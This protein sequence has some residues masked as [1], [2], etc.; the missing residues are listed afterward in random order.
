MDLTDKEQAFLESTRSAAM[1]TLRPDGRPHAVRV[2]FVL[3]DGKLW[4]SGTRSRVRNAHLRRDPRCTLFVFDPAYSYLT[5]E[6]NATIIDSPE[7]P[8]MSLRLFRAMQGRPAGNLLWQGAE[9]TPEEFL[10]IMAEEQRIIYE[11]E[12]VRTYG[13]YG[14]M[15][16]R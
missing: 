11:F 14:D 4:V 5:L 6:A 1:V 13:L 10:Q 9:C 8:E 16:A 15:A 7:V 2:G 12:V 3:M